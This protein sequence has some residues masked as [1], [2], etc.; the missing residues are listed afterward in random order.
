MIDDDSCSGTDLCASQC[1]ARNVGG[2][3]PTLSEFARTYLLN[4]FRPLGSERRV[5]AVLV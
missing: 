2:K 4:S 1:P 3:C 5:A